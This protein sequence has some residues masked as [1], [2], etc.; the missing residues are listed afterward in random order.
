MRDAPPTCAM[1]R[2]DCRPVSGGGDSPSDR[3]PFTAGPRRDSASTGTVACFPGRS[4]TLLGLASPSA[5]RLYSAGGRRLADPIRRLLAMVGELVTLLA[6][7][8]CGR[9]LAVAARSAALCGLLAAAAG[10][11]LPLAL[12][13][14]LVLLPLLLLGSAAGWRWPGPL[15]TLRLWLCAPATSAAD[16][17]R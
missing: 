10:A 3:R 14:L 17:L 8:N 15:E 2:S 9:A 11:G 7:M 13:L 5:L 12:L 4:R 16:R 6:C 1:A